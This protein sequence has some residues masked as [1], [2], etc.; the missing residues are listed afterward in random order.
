MESIQIDEETWTDDNEKLLRQWM[1]E[2]QKLSRRHSEKA[3][4]NQRLYNLWGLPSI[5]IP[6]VMSGL[7]GMYSP[8]ENEWV[9]VVSMVGFVL[10]GTISGVLNF[11][12]Y[13][14]KT[15]LHFASSIK[16][17]ELA[18]D[19]ETELARSIPHREDIKVFTV[20]TKMKRSQLIEGAPNI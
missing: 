7:T 18:T 2:S 6:L 16:F 11:F 1:A 9:T 14:H 5:F 20:Q 12:K 17:A 13:G 15:E 8:C 19:I 10:S 4:N 3:I